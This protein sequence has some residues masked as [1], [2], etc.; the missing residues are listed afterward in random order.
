M[1]YVDGSESLIVKGVT[2]KDVARTITIAA[3]NTAIAMFLPYLTLIAHYQRKLS[4]ADI[5]FIMSQ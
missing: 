1:T 4:S 5:D 2:K 3:R